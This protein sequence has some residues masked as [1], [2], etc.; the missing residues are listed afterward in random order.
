M[1]FNKLQKIIK[2]VS[3]THTAKHPYLRRLTAKEGFKGLLLRTDKS[4]GGLTSASWKRADFPVC[5]ATSVHP[6]WEELE[7]I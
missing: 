7:E 4:S 2:Q 1:S 3:W 6:V 5:L